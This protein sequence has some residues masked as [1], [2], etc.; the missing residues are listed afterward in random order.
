MNVKYS[1]T[2]CKHWPY[3][4]EKFGIERDKI[5][6]FE[7]I[8]AT[9]PSES[10]FLAL[11]RKKPYL[12]IEELCDALIKVQANKVFNIVQNA[13]KGKSETIMTD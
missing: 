4:G 12:R 1:Q 9:S 11:E 10:M 5:D 7:S 8:D 13:I 6:E 2:S 3:L